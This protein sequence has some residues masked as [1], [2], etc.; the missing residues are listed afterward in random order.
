MQ[1]QLE[2][3]IMPVKNALTKSDLLSSRSCLLSQPQLLSL[4]KSQTIQR[5]HLVCQRLDI[6]PPGVVNKRKGS[7]LET[8]WQAVHD[9]PGLLFTLDGL[10]V[11][12]VG[13][14]RQLTSPHQ[15]IA[16]KMTIEVLPTTKKNKRLEMVLEHKEKRHNTDVGTIRIRYSNGL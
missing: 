3:W 14:T 7:L 12:Q 1:W 11:G 2:M 6:C 9:L 4:Y 13:L 10:G 5:T 8:L 15:T 16:E